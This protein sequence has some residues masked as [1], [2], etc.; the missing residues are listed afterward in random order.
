MKDKIGE[1][2][3]V[4][5]RLLIENLPRFSIIS[6]D[7]PNQKANMNAI[8]TSQAWLNSIVSER[9]ILE[10]SPENIWPATDQIYRIG[11][12]VLVYAEEKNE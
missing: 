1:N 7:I 9:R 12:E 6:N 8:K 4:L 5:S 3:L 11:K 2:E 10:A